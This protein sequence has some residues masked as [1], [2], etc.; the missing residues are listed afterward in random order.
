MIFHH[1]LGA[2]KLKVHLQKCSKVST[3]TGCSGKIYLNIMREASNIFY[4]LIPFLQELF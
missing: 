2:T 4:G 1:I 3:R